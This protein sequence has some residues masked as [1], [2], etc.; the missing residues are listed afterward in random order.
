MNSHQSGKIFRHLP[1]ELHFAEHLP[2]LYP[3]LHV[4]GIFGYIFPLPSL[5]IFWTL[6]PIDSVPKLAEFLLH[7]LSLRLAEA[8]HHDF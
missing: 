7:L 5:R 8:R 4:A 1:Y 6:R 3:F 2:K